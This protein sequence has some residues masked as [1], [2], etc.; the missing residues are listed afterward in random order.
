MITGYHPA[1]AL[2]IAREVGLAVEGAP[3]LIGDEL[4]DDDQVLG[5][6]IDRD[7]AVV[8]RVSPEH[9]LRIASALRERGHV[10][11]MTGDGVMGQP[12]RH[13]AGADGRR[14]AQPAEP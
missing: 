11:A 5:A 1:T 3:V 4:P 10:V 9:K 14:G 7:G 8:A 2:A 6:L 12:H 13:Q